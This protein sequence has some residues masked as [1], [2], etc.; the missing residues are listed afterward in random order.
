MNVLINYL[1]AVSGGAV[2]YMLQVTPRLVK[3][4]DDSDGRHRAIFLLHEEQRRLMPDL[5]DHCCRIVHGVRPAGYRRLVWEQFNL[6]ALV[7][8]EQ[9]DVLFMPCQVAPRVGGGRR[10]L[11]LGNMEVFH[12]HKYRYSFKQAL[13]N[14]LLKGQTIRC[15]KGADRV[16]AISDYTREFLE[17]DMAVPENR[18]RRIYHGR[19]ARFSPVPD[20]SGDHATLAALGIRGDYIFTCGSLLPY[21]RCEDVIAAF[22]ALPRSAGYNVSLVI[23]GTG[24]E[25]LYDRLIDQAIKN[26]GCA[27]RIYRVGHVS[28][29]TMAVLYRRSRV[30]VIAS[31]VE[32]CPNIAIEAMA[33]GC[34]IVASDANPLPEMFSDAAIHF[35]MRDISTL[36]SSILRLL[37]DDKERAGNSARALGRA[38]DFS[39]DRCASETYSALTEW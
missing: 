23:A 2:A 4:F 11:M 37:T 9:A 10:V 33:S 38:L 32:A 36:S 27:E 39:W 12:Y 8:K 31:E 26:S 22:A 17:N 19:D 6:P 24:T 35:P 34:A 3:L 20:L 14:R 21:R 30:C 5:P 15:L 18:T 1:S 28:L 25:P 13:R 29:E 16:I 7:R